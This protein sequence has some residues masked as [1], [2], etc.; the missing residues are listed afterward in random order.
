MASLDYDL[1]QAFQAFGIQPEFE[2]TSEERVKFASVQM[3]LEIQVRLDSALFK[4]KI[5][6]DQ[7]ALQDD[8][9]PRARRTRQ[10]GRLHL[11]SEDEIRL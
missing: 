8:N 4:L 9:S 2:W 6:S 3:S 10:Q 11:L 5:S 7:E 1:A